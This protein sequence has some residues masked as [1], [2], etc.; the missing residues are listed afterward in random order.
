V[1]GQ[2]IYGPELVYTG[3]NC[4][5][6][7]RSAPPGDSAESPKVLVCSSRSSKHAR[8][9]HIHHRVEV[10]EPRSVRFTRR[11]TTTTPLS[12][13]ARRDQTSVPC[14][15]DIPHSTAAVRVP[16][17]GAWPA[18]SRQPA[19]GGGV[20]P[21]R[22]AGRWSRS[23]FEAPAGLQSCRPPVRTAHKTR[24]VQLPRL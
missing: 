5:P 2:H 3:R 13:R 12:C 23:W 16:V 4:L 18:G 19:S 9:I 10:V 11:T 8:R 6:L 15:I 20:M 21:R 1:W 22:E 17:A 7:V 14:V 24:I